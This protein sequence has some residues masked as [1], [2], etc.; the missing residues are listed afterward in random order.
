MFVFKPISLQS[1][2]C[3]VPIEIFI[4]V[5]QRTE[6]KRGV[7]YP[8]FVVLFLCHFVVLFLNSHIPHRSIIPAKPCFFIFVSH[9]VFYFL[10]YAQHRKGGVPP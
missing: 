1:D 6:E 4:G 10:F 8:L 5:E 3:G 7:L 9:P 2:A